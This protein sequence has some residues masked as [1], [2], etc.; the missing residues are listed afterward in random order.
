MSKFLPLAIGLISAASLSARTF[1]SAD[2][3]K[4]LEGELVSASASGKVVIRHNDS[5][6]NVTAE[7]GAFSAEDQRYFDEFLK[8]ATKRGSL[9]VSADKKTEKVPPSSS[10]LYL[11]DKRKEFF[12]IS[13]SNGGSVDVG[14]ITA[15]YDIFVLRYDKQGKKTTDLVSGEESLGKLYSGESGRFVTSPVEITV[16]CATTSS[17]PKCKTFAAAV[18]KER[19]IGI[20]VR[21]EDSEARPISEFHS[22]PAVKS[23]AEKHSGESN[24]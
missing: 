10:G 19:V 11:Y 13:V 18:E 9:K 15:K 16:G 23:A 2:G 14:E 1:T 24:R 21:L 3:S 5:G 22:S 4:T 20:R 8:E 17:C 7:A 12:T 6:R